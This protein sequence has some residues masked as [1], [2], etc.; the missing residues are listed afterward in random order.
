MIVKG[1]ARG[2]GW[3]LGM[4]QFYGSLSEIYTYNLSYLKLIQKY[5]LQT[6][7]P[8][9]RDCKSSGKQPTKET[10]VMVKHFCNIKFEN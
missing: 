8:V 3:L 7:A 4:M 2:W 5:R 6:W 10:T 1:Q 9:I